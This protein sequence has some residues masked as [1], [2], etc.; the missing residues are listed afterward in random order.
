MADKEI[1]LWKDGDK[2]IVDRGNY[3]M[4][5]ARKVHRL[6]LEKYLDRQ[7]WLVTDVDFLGWP[8]FEYFSR[9][10]AIAYLKGYLQGQTRKR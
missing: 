8:R 7:W 6:R 1:V 2:Q 5:G 10:Q 3:W 9:Q 4:A